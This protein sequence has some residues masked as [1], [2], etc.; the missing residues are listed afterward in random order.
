MEPV[1]PPR[2]HTGRGLSSLQCSL[3]SQPG[4]LGATAAQLLTTSQ[5]LQHTQPSVL[6]MAGPGHTWLNRASPI[7]HLVWF[8]LSGVPEFF[9]SDSSTPSEVSSSTDIVAEC[10]SCC[11]YSSGPVETGGASDVAPITAT[12]PNACWLCSPLSQVTEES[13]RCL[14]GVFFRNKALPLLGLYLNMDR[15]WWGTI[16]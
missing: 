15:I 2:N 14:R 3:L 8:S 1:L 11:S 13:P 9:F 12:F 10:D 7:T 4:I 5:C 6:V 16:D